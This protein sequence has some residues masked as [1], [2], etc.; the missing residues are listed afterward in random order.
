VCIQ[1]IDTAGNSVTVAGT[2]R[3]GTPA[4]TGDK[5]SVG[6]LAR[7]EANAATNSFR[8]TVRAVHKDVSLAIKNGF[9]AVL[10]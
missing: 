3:T 1:G 5:V 6:I 8:V 2:F 7:V 4:P 10:A 9:K